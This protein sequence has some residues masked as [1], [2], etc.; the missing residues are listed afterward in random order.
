MRFNQP[1][2]HVTN[3]CA[4]AAALLAVLGILGP[5]DRASADYTF[6]TLVNFNRVNGSSPTGGLVADTQGNLYGTTGA[7][8]STTNGTI[9]ELSAGTYSLTTLHTFHFASDGEGPT[10]ALIEDASGNMYGTTVGGPGN[11]SGT[12]FEISAGSHQFTS[13]ASLTPSVGNGPGGP[14]LEDSQGDFFSVTGGGGAL[15]GGA[16]VE[17]PAGSHT[18]K[19]VTS[20]GSGQSPNGGLAVDSQGDLYATTI[21]GGT[22][23]AGSVVEYAP[24]Y[25]TFGLFSFQ[26]YQGGMSPPDGLWPESGLISDASGDIFGTTAVGGANGGGTIFE[27]SVSGQLTTLASFPADES[28]AYGDLILDS[29]GDIFG[30]TENDG[31]NNGDGTIFELPAGSNTP[32]VLWTFDGQDGDFPE[33]PL[34]ADAYGDLFGTTNSGGQFNDGTVFE[35]QFSPLPS[36]AWGGLLLMGC[37]AVI[38][39]RQRKHQ[40]D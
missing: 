29:K 18:F 9:F 27:I 24:G 35:L 26:F 10:S 14:L 1:F 23:G 3:R 25:G 16:I 13:L 12:I 31:G 38:V 7:G 39:Y 34:Y 21:H 32:I 15:G 6:E 4:A 11:D 37:A 19:D 5:L 22:N 40:T 8:G 2:V 28:F 20:F 33:G 30:A 36:A 17:L